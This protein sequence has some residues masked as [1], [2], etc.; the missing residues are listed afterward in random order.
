MSRGLWIRSEGRVIAEA[1]S[2]ATP[3]TEGAR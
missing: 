3:Y 1:R 2:H